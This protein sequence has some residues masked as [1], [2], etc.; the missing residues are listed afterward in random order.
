TT[1]DAYG[2]QPSAMRPSPQ[3]MSITR[4]RRTSPVPPYSRSSCCGGG[5]SSDEMAGRSRPTPLVLAA[6]E[7][8]AMTTRR[9]RRSPRQWIGVTLSRPMPGGWTM[10]ALLAHIAFWDA[11]AI[12]FLDKW[13]PS[14]EPT[15]Y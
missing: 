13:G 10:P 14:G 5:R 6:L 12:Y 2:A 11:R 15:T 7:L 4:F 1:S 8:V 9:Y 3:P